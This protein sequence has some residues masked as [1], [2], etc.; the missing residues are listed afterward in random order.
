MNPFRIDQ[1]LLT[2]MSQDKLKTAFNYKN[3]KWSNPFRRQFLC[4]NYCT[5][6]LCKNK[7]SLDP[8]SSFD[9]RK[10]IYFSDFFYPIKLANIKYL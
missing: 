3:F 4:T 7:F 6:L 8:R 10:I 1:I 2:A 9:T 5:I